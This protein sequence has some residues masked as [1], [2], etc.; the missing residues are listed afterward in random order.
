M[1]KLETVNERLKQGEGWIGYRNT[2][3]GRQS[4]FLYFSFYRNGKQVFVNTKTNEPEE[5]Y[6]QLLDARGKTER[7][8][9]VLPT[10]AARITYEDLRRKYI[11]DNPQ[12]ELSQKSQLIQLDT[13]FKNARATSI[14]PDIL[15]KYINQRRKDGVS[16]PT[17]R[18]ELT[19]LRAMFNLAR[20]E[21]ALSHDQIPYFPM[22]E[23]SLPA[24]QYITPETF[25]TILSFLP[26]GN[27]RGERGR[28]S[29]SNLR[30]FFLFLYA[31][32]CRLGA[33]QSIFWK[34]INENCTVIEIPATETKNKEPLRLP[35]KGKQLEPLVKELRK[36]ARNDGPVFDSANYQE[37]WARA[38]AKAGLGEYDEETHRKTGG[39][40]IHDCRCSGAINLLDSGVDEGTVL[41]IGGWKTRT[42]LD[43]YNVT[44]MTR[45]SAAMEKVGQYVTDRV[46]VAG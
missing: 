33:A 45:L 29:S 31:T 3:K 26:N 1:Q 43:R 46:A 6:V 41:K 18:R 40:R 37:E 12:R 44:T 2:G 7:G 20:R 15:R 35:L 10:E 9:L 8:I 14:T 4:K 23:D 27:K 17:I 22:P 24:G 34:H 19:N 5:A 11:D 28:R 25:E 16:G 13:F 21:R 30:P 42:M 32:A 36:L 38:C 39:V